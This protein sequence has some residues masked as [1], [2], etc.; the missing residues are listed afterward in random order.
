MQRGDSHCFSVGGKG[1]IRLWI[2]K[3]F[4]MEAMK[5]GAVAAGGHVPQHTLDMDHKT[6]RFQVS[7]FLAFLAIT[8]HKDLSCPTPVGHDSSWTSAITEA[9]Q[10]PS[11]SPQPLLTPTRSPM[12]ATRRL[13]PAPCKSHGGSFLAAPALYACP[14][15]SH[16][17]L[18]L[19]AWEQPWLRGLPADNTTA[20]VEGLS[21][22]PAW[23]L[24]IKKDGGRRWEDETVPSNTLDPTCPFCRG[25]R[26]VAGVIR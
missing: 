18:C 20:C 3:S 14:D 11:H 9:A 17:P 4:N 1:R 12:P 6:S 13:P 22:T 8:S 23:L 10:P 24:L 26:R 2:Q 25:R 5:I 19:P 16:Q 7:P 15:R 21:P